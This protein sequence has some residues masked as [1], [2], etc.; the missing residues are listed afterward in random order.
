MLAGPSR[1]SFTIAG[2][3]GRR[4][5]TTQFFIAGGFLILI[6]TALVGQLLSQ[7]VERDALEANGSATALF[8]EAMAGPLVQTL[9]NDPVLSEQSRARLDRLFD[10]ETF[11][12]RFPYLEIWHPDGRIVYSNSEGMIGQ[13]FLLPEG[14]RSAL[15]GQITST[16]TDL[17]ADEHVIRDWTEDFV[18]IYLPLRE[19]GTGRIIAVAEIHEESTAIGRLIWQIRIIN[20]SLVLCVGAIF[21]AGLYGIVARAAHQIEAQERQLYDQID[22]LRELSNHNLALKNRIEGASRKLSEMNENFIRNIGSELHDGPAQLIGFAILNSEQMRRERDPERRAELID[23]QEG[24]LREAQS[25]IRHLARGMLLPDILEL[26]ITTLIERLVLVHEART[27]SQVTV[28]WSGK[29]PALPPALRICTFRFVQEGLTNA[30]KHGADNR[31]IVCIREQEGHWRV[32]L[33]NRIGPSCGRAT[34][35]EAMGLIAMRDRIE[36]LGGT[37][38]FEVDAEHAKAT[39]EFGGAG[40]G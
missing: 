13:T 26:E 20:W 6:A 15:E 19:D 7:I 4:R 28:R 36:G 21:M 38:T 23:R 17:D 33:T 30:F 40:Y 5:V 10:D 29:F 3:F 14:A 24:V 16:L 1:S 34:G 25:E 37:F 32:S 9:A 27:G 12:T 8:V 22:K 18:E 31:Q 11:R 39:M 35:G 2:W